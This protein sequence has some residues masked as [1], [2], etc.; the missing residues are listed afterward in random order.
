VILHWLGH[1]PFE[2]AANI[3]LWAEK[4]GHTVTSTKLYANEPLPEINKIDALAVMG[5]PMNVYQY[6]Q[7]PWLLKEK[8]FIEQ[9][10]RAEIPIIGVCLGAQLI[11]DVLGAK[12]VQNSQIEIGWYPV[13]LTSKGEK[14]SLLNGVSS[15]FT[16]FHWHG[17]TFQIP[18]GALHLAKSEACENQAFIYGKSVLGLQFH[19]EYSK[20]SIQKMLTNCS[21]ELVDAPFIQDEKNIYERLENVKITTQFLFTLLDNWNYDNVTE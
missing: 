18:L 11:A 9:A 21:H 5:G 19:L 13:R 15:E 12:V 4:R 1:V 14:T 17:D 6:R 7:Y 8:Q 20:D 2:D 3:G 10:I 16:A